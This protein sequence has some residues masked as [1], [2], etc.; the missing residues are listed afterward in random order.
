M[1]KEGFHVKTGLL[2][3]LSVTAV[4]L[5]IVTLQIIAADAGARSVSPEYRLSIEQPRY[6][7]QW[8]GYDLTVEYSYTKEQGQI[9]LSGNI[10]FATYLA[11]GYSRLH[12]FRLGAIFLDENGSIVEEIGLAT[13][14][15]SLDPIPFKRKINLPSN[16]ISMA[17]TYQGNATSSGGNGAGDTSFSFYPIH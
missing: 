11:L 9:D 1:F 17:F 4:A 10:R 5:L 2:C 14:R 16:A 6:S 13:N 3:L 12:D 7:G 15:G 8:K